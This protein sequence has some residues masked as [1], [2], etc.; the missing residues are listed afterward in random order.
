MGGGQKGQPVCLQ[1][2]LSVRVRAC[3]GE[4]QREGHRDALLSRCLQTELGRAFWDPERTSSG[5]GTFHNAA[6]K[7][8]QAEVPW[9]RSP[10]PFSCG[11]Q[12][13]PWAA[14]AASPPALFYLDRNTTRSGANGS[15]RATYRSG[16]AVGGGAGGWGGDAPFCLFFSFFAGFVFFFPAG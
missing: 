5:S 9:P 12:K 2:V 6:C 8:F 3:A 13:R 15:I 14:E 7:R 16:S 10:W 11:L 1:V 4:R